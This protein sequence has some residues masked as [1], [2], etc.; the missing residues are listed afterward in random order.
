MLEILTISNPVHINSTEK[1]DLTTGKLIYLKTEK[2]ESNICNTSS[3][4]Q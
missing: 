2:R 4:P 3:E 1:I